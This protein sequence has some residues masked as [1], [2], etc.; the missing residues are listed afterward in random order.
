MP[1]LRPLGLA[2]HSTGALPGLGLQSM[3]QPGI[4]SSWVDTRSPH[5]TDSEKDGGEKKGM[6]CTPWELWNIKS[7]T[8][9]RLLQTWIWVIVMNSV[10]NCTWR[11]SRN[12]ILWKQSCF[13]V[14]L[15]QHITPDM[16]TDIWVSFCLQLRGTAFGT[17]LFGKS[18]DLIFYSFFL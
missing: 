13:L 1:E 8:E 10:R 4:H 18:I 2:Q 7:N 11:Q 17:V 6:S 5:L 3:F 15:C 16:L 9:K 14:S 12:S